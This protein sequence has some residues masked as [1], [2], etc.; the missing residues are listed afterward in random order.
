MGIGENDLRQVVSGSAP[1]DLMEIAK[2][3]LG[4][5]SRYADPFT[6]DEL[7][8]P[9]EYLNKLYKARKFLDKLKMPVEEG[10]SGMGDST[11]ARLGKTAKST[12]NDVKSSSQAVVDEFEAAPLKIGKRLKVK[13]DAQARRRTADLQEQMNNEPEFPEVRPTASK[14]LV[15]EFE[16]VPEINL[17]NNMSRATT[18]QMATEG[19]DIATTD[20][21]VSGVA[22][23]IQKAKNVL[24]K[25]TEDTADLD[26]FG[27]GD[28]INAGL[29][30]ATVATM[31]AGLFDTPVKPET[32]AQGEQ[33]GV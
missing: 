25:A 8:I 9:E 29:G 12:Y 17:S 27:I 13:L 2:Q 3:R 23:S 19:E 6:S 16:D 15:N 5:G 24:T 33:L 1:R 31:I 7:D 21:S 22:G 18:Q 26:E 30:I 20:E 4:A 32:V 10:G 28:L 11:L 14:P